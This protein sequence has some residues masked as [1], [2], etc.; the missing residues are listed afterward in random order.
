M[1]DSRSNINDI[2]NTFKQHLF[3]CLD[4]HIPS[5][6]IKSNNRLPWFNH[7][8]K[9]MLRKKQSLYNQAKRTKNWLNYK[10]Y[11][12]ECKRQ[13]RKAEWNYINSAIL[14]GMEKNNTKPFWKY[15]KSTKQDNIGVAPL[16]ERGHLI[17]NSKEKA[18]ILIKQF[19]SVFTRE[20]VNKMPKTHRRIQQNIPNIKITQDGVAK[21]LRNINPSKASGPDNIPNRVIK[22]CADN[23]APALTIIVQ[24]SID[25]GKLPNDLLNA[26]VSCIFKKGDKHAAENYRPVSLTSVPCKLLEHIICGHMMIHLEKH[27]VLTSLNHGFRSDYSCETQLVVTIHDMLQP[28]DKGKQVDIGILDFSKA[29]DTI[30]HDRLLHKI[31]QYGI[32]GPHTAH[33]LPNKKE[34]ASGT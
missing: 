4:K 12:K 27:N 7:K 6:I 20:K 9:K 15:V 33:I 25:H 34:N 32:R 22:Q 10:H 30:P 13:I 3:K 1:G 24:R 5:K 21:L 8:I 11:Q 28:F 29:F 2:W 17:N 19:L 26:N 18:Q 16:K 23:P 31:D 14:E